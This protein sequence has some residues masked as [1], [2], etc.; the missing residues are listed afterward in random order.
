MRT[1]VHTHLVPPIPA[2]VLASVGL[3]ARDGAV[4]AGDH[5][6]G[7][8]DLYRPERLVE[9]LRGAG[10][11]RALV[12][13]PPPLYR[14]HDDPRVAAAWVRAVNDALLDVT[15][16]HEALV[17][18]G[19]LPLEHPAVALAEAE[20]LMS[21][22]WA[23]LSGCAGGR[24]V[25]LADDAFEPLWTL[26]T[27]R[28]RP[29]LLH[30]G[31]TPDMRMRDFYLENLLG[32]PVETGLAVAQLLLGGVLDRHPSLRIGL[33]HCGGVAPALVGRW[34]RGVDTA[35]PGIDRP[36]A[37]LASEARRLWVD[38]LAHDP[39]AVDL[40]IAVVGEEHVLVGSDWPFPMGSADPIGLVSHRGP[41]A[42]R[43]MSTDNAA[44][45]LG[46]DAPKR[47]G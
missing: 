27:T 2:A 3:D 42:V 12:S 14:Q 26:L 47:D 5:V 22:G 33:V 1:D 18:L 25:S 16:A 30:P 46:E 9:W 19:H 11:D 31:A 43:R 44:R 10:L 13:V 39:S 37:D 6:V 45:F 7:P 34:Q 15:A 20:R 8:R 35:R 38:A 28:D 41:D 36:S 29:L 40:A 23:G 4:A 32:N 17:P 21:D 24:S